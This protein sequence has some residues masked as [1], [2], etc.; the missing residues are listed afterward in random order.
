MSKDKDNNVELSPQLKKTC[1]ALARAQERREKRLKNLRSVYSYYDKNNKVTTDNMLLLDFA[2]ELAHKQYLE[3][4]VYNLLKSLPDNRY[5]DFQHLSLVRLGKYDKIKNDFMPI[6]M[7]F[8]FD[9]K[10][11]IDIL[12]R[13]KKNNENIK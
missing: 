5:K 2:T 8:I 6:K 3:R 12:E 11:I 7:K 9:F 1:E 4:H 10:Y 13:D